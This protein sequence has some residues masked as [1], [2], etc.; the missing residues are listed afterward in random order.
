M[1]ETSFQSPQALDPLG[2]ELPIA[3]VEKFL[4]RSIVSNRGAHLSG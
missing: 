2:N 4:D 1:G 3:Q